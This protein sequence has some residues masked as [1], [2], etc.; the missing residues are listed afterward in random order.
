M[1]PKLSKEEL[2][3]MHEHDEQCTLCGRSFVND[4]I[5]ALGFDDKE[6]TQMVCQD[7]IPKITPKARYCHR[8]RAYQKPLPD[9]MLWRFMD[10]AKFISILKERALYLTRI[11]QFSDP[12]ECAIGL[13]EHKVKYDAFYMN[14]LKY[15]IATTPGTDKSQLTPEYIQENVERLFNEMSESNKMHRTRIFVNCW[16]KNTVESEAMWNLYVKDMSQGVA[17]Q[18]TY[19]RLYNA[20]GRENMPAIG[21]VN[22]IDYAKGTVYMQDVQWYK[23]KSFEHE[24]EVRIVQVRDDAP[25]S[26]LGVSVPVDLDVLIEVVIIA[27]S[28]F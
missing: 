22:Y 8:C 25:P 21:E 15:A 17:I 5:I 13:A 27:P 6:A 18:T 4:E 20:I 1:W 23:R 9:A 26:C 2:I 12:F 7:C 3:F 28:F 10:L 24:K 19:E 11:D 16:H 14:F